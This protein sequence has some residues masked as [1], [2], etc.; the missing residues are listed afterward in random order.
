M[1]SATF[2]FKQPNYG[3]GLY[4][5]LFVNSVSEFVQF[6]GDLGAVTRTLWPENSEFKAYL[7]YHKNLSSE[8]HPAGERSLT[9]IHGTS[10]I[11]RCPRYVPD[12][13]H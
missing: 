1:G 11:V 9:T 7:D 5:L 12:L 6:L 13:D 2:A 3:S 8:G 4:S 10:L